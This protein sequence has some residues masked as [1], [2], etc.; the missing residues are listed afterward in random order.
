MPSLLI[1]ILPPIIFTVLALTSLVALLYYVFFAPP[2]PPPPPRVAPLPKEEYKRQLEE[3]ARGLAIER[4][5]PVTASPFHEDS[6]PAYWDGE[7]AREK[8]RNGVQLRRRGFVSR[9][10][11]DLDG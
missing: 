3:Y 1:D 9:S 8:E 10:Q 6:I 2:P 7:G 4:Q 5:G 11:D